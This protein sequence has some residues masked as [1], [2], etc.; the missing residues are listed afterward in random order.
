MRV[1]MYIYNS[2]GS[3]HFRARDPCFCRYGGSS[4]R[5]SRVCV[6]A[7]LGLDVGKFS[8]V[9]QNALALLSMADAVTLLLCGLAGEGGCAEQKWGREEVAEIRS[10]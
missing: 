3:V 7:V 10:C 8:T 2:S 1:Y 6:S 4:F 5:E 9:W